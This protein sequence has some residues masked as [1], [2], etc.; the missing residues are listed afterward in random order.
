[1][2][3]TTSE[4][5]QRYR[6]Q[7]ASGDKSRLQVILEKVDA[8]KLE[9]ICEAEGISKTDFVRLAINHWSEK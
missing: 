5:Q 1:M 9:A 7:I 3:K 2:D 6:Q 8:G 4:R